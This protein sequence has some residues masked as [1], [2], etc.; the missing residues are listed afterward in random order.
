MPEASEQKTVR[1]KYKLSNWEIEIEGDRDLI[2]EVVSEIKKKELPPYGGMDTGGVV[3][4]LY[5]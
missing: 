3:P 1:F 4:G 2:K 5:T